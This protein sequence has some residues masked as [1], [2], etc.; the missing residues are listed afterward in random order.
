[1]GKKMAIWGRKAVPR[2][3]F[4]LFS[5]LYAIARPP[6]TAPSLFQTNAAPLNPLPG[7]GE[8]LGHSPECKL[9]VPDPRSAW[10]GSLI[11]CWKLRRRW[12]RRSPH[13]ISSRNRDSTTRCGVCTI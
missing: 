13:M 4:G 1:M 5:G 10:E 6:Y 2:A 11:V 7:P 8:G 3:T 12:G 9:A